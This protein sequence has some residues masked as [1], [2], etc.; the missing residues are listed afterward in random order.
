MLGFLYVY[1][2][3]TPLPPLSVS[4]FF[5]FFFFRLSSFLYVFLWVRVITSSLYFWFS[6]S[7]YSIVKFVVLLTVFKSW[8]CS[9][10]RPFLYFEWIL[11]LQIFDPRSGSCISFQIGSSNLSKPTLDVSWCST[12]SEVTKESFS[13]NRLWKLW[14][15]LNGLNGCGTLFSRTMVY[16][17]RVI[18]IQFGFPLLV[19]LNNNISLVIT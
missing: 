2:G 9:C 14:G 4:G 10:S 13:R 12:E 5:F 3:A 8:D 7:C 18:C 16:C 17:S 6:C 1:Y 11:S 15:I 19:L